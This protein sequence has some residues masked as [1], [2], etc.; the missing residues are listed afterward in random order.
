MTNVNEKIENTDFTVLDVINALCCVLDGEKEHDL[1]YQTGIAEEDCA[2][3][4]QIRNSVEQ[5]W[6]QK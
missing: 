6:L 1:H 4:F 5:F 3:I 2:K